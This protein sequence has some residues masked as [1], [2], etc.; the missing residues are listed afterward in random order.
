MAELRNY[1]MGIIALMFV[2][3]M[4]VLFIIP[5]AASNGGYT[6]SN[7]QYTA[8]SNNLNNLNSSVSTF[9][10]Q[11]QNASSSTTT[12]IGGLDLL[13]GLTF[14]ISSIGPSIGLMFGLIGSSTG[15]FSSI[16]ALLGSV[17]GV[18]AISFSEVLLFLMFSISGALI[19]LA[20]IYKWFD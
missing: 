4:A 18:P 19:I 1:V 7:P 17:I 2:G 20:F 11:M 3:L 5:Q 9:N 16:A 8:L 6:V 15:V 10:Q 14:A 13:S 12:Q